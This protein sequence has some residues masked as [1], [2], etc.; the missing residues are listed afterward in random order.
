MIKGW[1]II[2]Q[3][4]SESQGK[5]KGDGELTFPPRVQN[6]LRKAV[7]D[8]AVTFVYRRGEAATRRSKET[9]PR[10]AR[11][12]SSENSRMRTSRSQ[13]NCRRKGTI[14]RRTERDASFNFRV[15]K[16]SKDLILTSGFAMVEF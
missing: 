11:E 6:N 1:K 13:W 3:E 7:N 10:T 8:L 9:L 4:T 15:H 16:W 12:A 14:C 2:V 5:T